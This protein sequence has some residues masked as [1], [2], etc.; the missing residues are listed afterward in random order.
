MKRAKMILD[1]FFHPP[2][3]ILYTVPPASFAALIFV[4]ASNREEMLMCRKVA[5]TREQI[6]TPLFRKIFHN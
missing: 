1:R 2:A 6:A 3:W 5:Q 4:F